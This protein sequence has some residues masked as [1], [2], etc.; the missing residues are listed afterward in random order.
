MGEHIARY[1]NFGRYYNALGYYVY[2]MDHQG[3]GLS[4]GTRCYFEK[5]DYV[6]DDYIE[7]VKKVQNNFIKEEEDYKR[8]GNGKTLK[9]SLPCFLFGHSMGGLIAINVAYQC[10]KSS[11]ISS[12][13]KYFVLSFIN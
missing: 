3:H 7:Y 10:N 12:S 11:K 6:I 4:Q 9:S 13:N 5:F 2:G 1:E 8:S